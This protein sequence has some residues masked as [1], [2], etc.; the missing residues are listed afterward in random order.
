MS[1]E[2]DLHTRFN[3]LLQQHRGIVLK[4]AASYCW[5]P[6]DRAEL[7]QDIS[8]CSYGVHFPAM[9]PAGVFPPGCTAS[10]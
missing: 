3:A 1:L 6:D 5:N 10:P 8:P 4:V 7:A 2:T 9:T